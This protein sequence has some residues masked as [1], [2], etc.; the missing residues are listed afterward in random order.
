MAHILPHVATGFSAE[1]I[2]N[3][4]QTDAEPVANPGRDKRSQEASETI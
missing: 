1:G 4:S 2:E 3:I